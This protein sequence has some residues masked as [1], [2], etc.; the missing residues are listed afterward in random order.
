MLSEVGEEEEQKDEQEKEEEEEEDEEEEV[1]VD[2]EEKQTTKKEPAGRA[3]RENDPPTAQ[4]THTR[5]RE[6]NTRK[7]RTRDGRK[8]RRAFTTYLPNRVDE[9]V[10]QFHP[11]VCVYDHANTGLLHSVREHANDRHT[12]HHDAQSKEGVP[13]DHEIQI[14][15]RAYTSRNTHCQGE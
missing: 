6:N 7:Q 5:T 15:N 14:D 2:K 4:G 9:F 13:S 1:V 11:F 10:D 8:T 12:A 3:T